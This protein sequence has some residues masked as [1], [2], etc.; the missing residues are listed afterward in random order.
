MNKA[1][2]TLKD[3]L[4]EVFIA[5]DT[6]EIPMWINLCLVHS[7]RFGSHLGF[8]SAIVFQVTVTVIG[9]L[10]CSGVNIALAILSPINSFKNPINSY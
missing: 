3:G 8:R 6:M 2:V 1:R 9:R 7:R 5:F 10:Q 4:V